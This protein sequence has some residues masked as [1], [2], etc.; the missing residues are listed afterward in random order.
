[1]QFQWDLA[2]TT[3]TGD[4]H[5]VRWSSVA[6]NT[7]PFYADL[8]S[9]PRISTLTLPP[10]HHI[11]TFPSR[12]VAVRELKIVAMAGCAL[13]Q[14]RYSISSFSLSNCVILGQEPCFFLFFFFCFILNPA[15]RAVSVQ[16]MGRLR[17]SSR[18]GRQGACRSRS[19]APCTRW[20]HR[21]SRHLRTHFW[22][23]IKGTNRGLTTSDSRS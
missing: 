7:L 4:V 3:S 10:S 22:L 6:T 13:Y 8:T 18:C 23:C 1:M 12:S 15:D 11:I 17:A 20:S 2:F 19:C 9:L 5:T 21:C 16:N 14:T